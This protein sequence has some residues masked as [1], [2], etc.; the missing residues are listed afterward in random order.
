MRATIQDIVTSALVMSLS[1][2]VFAQGAAAEVGAALL[3]ERGQARVEPG[4]SSARG[5]FF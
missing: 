1:G 3:V 4:G 2:A 5:K